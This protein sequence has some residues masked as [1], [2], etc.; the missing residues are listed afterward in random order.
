VIGRSLLLCRSV[1]F[2][3]I[4]ADW[5]EALRASLSE[6]QATGE[7]DH[8]RAVTPA[9]QHRRQQTRRRKRHV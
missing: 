1:S 4:G 7:L 8:G 2:E 5:H 9:L 6:P 3:P